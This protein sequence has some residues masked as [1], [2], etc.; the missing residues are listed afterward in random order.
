MYIYTFS[1]QISMFKHSTYHVPLPPVSAPFRYQNMQGAR[2]KAYRRCQNILAP[3]NTNPVSDVWF[4][5]KNRIR[6]LGLGIVPN[7]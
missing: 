4:G 3:L 7:V 1:F 6:S 5:I 2:R